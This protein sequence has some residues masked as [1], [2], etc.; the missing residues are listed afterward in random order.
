MITIPRLLRKARFSVAA[1]VAQR[2]ARRY[3]LAQDELLEYPAYSGFRA[4]C[5]LL[6]YL[7]AGKPPLCVVGNF[8][9]I[10]GSSTSNVIEAV[11][12]AVAERIASDE[13]CLIQ[14]YPHLLG[15]HKFS[16]VQLEKVPAS[17][18]TQGQALVGHEDQWQET[19]RHTTITRF[20]NPRWVPLSERELVKL[21]GQRAVC[22]LYAI[23]GIKGD[24][25]PQRLFGTTGRTLAEDI[26]AHNDRQAEALIAELRG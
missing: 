21:L 10:L 19:A 16:E 12:T 9:Q 20:A 23:A 11:A 6:V 3:W 17:T 18:V 7:A 26:R 25:L 24:Y 2:E 15:G 8:E 22:A 4:V 5:H 13:F 14:W 1:R